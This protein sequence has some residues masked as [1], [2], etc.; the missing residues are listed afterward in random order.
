M[1]NV[2]IY[3]EK[4]ESADSMWRR[5]RKATDRANVFRDAS[6]SQFFVSRSQRRAAKSQRARAK[7]KKE[8]GGA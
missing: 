6:R 4:D 5:F 8:N 2:T 3:C 7:V 1:V